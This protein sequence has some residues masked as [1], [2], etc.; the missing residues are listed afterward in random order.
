MMAIFTLLFSRIANVPTGG[1]PYPVFAFVGLVPVDDVRERASAA[2]RT[3]SSATQNLVSK[4]YF[5]RLV[6]PAA[7]CSRWVPDF[8]IGSAVLFVIMAV[9]GFM[10]PPD[11]GAAP[12]S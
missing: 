6:I 4:V 2:R 9:F 5:P 11:G 7:R 1:V 8:V 10:P 12:C 3:A